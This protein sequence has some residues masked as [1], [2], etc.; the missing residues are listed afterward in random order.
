M[1]PIRFLQIR[2]PIWNRLLSLTAKTGNKGVKALTE[3]ELHE[4]TKLYPTVAVDVARARL[5]GIDSVTQ[6]NLNQLAIK[7][8]GLL[9]TKKREKALK[10]FI[11]FILYDYPRLFRKSWMYFII[12]FTLFAGA[13]TGSY[14]TVRIN[15]S[16][17]YLFVPRGL[18]AVGGPEV[19]QEDIGER[20]RMARGDIMATYITLNNIQ[21][22]FFCFALGITA[23]IGT[24]WVLLMNSMM[25]GGFFAHFANHNLLFP[26]FSFLVPHGALELFAIVVAATAG[27]RMGLS[28]AMPG[29]FSRGVALR[30]GAK[31]AVLLVLGTIPMFIVAGLIESFITPSYLSGE[32]KIIIGISTLGIFLMYLFLFGLWNKPETVAIPSKN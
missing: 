11:N 22:A 6:R 32:Y 29:S 20:Y 27:L 14:L 21:V 4:M 3:E 16:S 10:P 19:S 12:A 17:A 13:V 1:N 24:C 15:P 5:H 9:Y 8:H 7:T 25:L 30:K 26:C 28:L 31:E 18:D 2:K 23:G